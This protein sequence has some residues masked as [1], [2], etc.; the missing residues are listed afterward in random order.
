MNM[1]CECRVTKAEIEDYIAMLCGVPVYNLMFTRL[2]DK[3][4]MFKH[5]CVHTGVTVLQPLRAELSYVDIYY[6][7]CPYCGKV[8]FYA[9]EV[10]GMY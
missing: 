2:E 4:A 7:V 1:Y 9:E 3:P 10:G 8:L 6:A 5:C